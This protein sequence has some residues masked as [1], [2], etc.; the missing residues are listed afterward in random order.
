MIMAQYQI[1]AITMLTPFLFFIFLN[2]AAC[3]CL[4]IGWDG[5]PLI[6]TGLIWLCIVLVTYAEH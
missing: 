4:S 3:L 1:S 5:L 2:A 6:H